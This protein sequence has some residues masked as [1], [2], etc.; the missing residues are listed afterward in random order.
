M[1]NVKHEFMAHYS[2]ETPKHDHVDSHIMEINST[3]ELVKLDQLPHL[4]PVVELILT[5]SRHLLLARLKSALRRIRLMESINSL[6]ASSSGAVVVLHTEGH[7]EG[8]QDHNG[9]AQVGNDQGGE[10]VQLRTR[11]LGYASH[12]TVLCC[13]KL[14]MQL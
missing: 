9:E 3:P 6:S 2:G 8:R 10:V 4:N 14:K 7:N 13:L 1:Y 5:N 11:A 12:I